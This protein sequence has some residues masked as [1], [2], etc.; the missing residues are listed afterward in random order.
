M[1]EFDP[2]T[3]Y[4]LAEKRP[5]LVRTPAGRTLAELTI[6]ALREGGIEPGDVRATATTL[7]RQ[8]QVARAHGRVQLAENLERAGELAGVPDD[9]I[10]EVYTALRPRRAGVAELEELAGR[11]DGEFGASRVAAFVREAARAYDERGLLA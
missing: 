3:D 7:G 6:E 1:G 8:A 10:L 11:L 9:L 5:D 4:P 2:V